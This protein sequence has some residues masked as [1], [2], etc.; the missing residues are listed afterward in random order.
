MLEKNLSQRRPD[1]VGINAGR[2]ERQK[3]LHRG[4]GEKAKKNLRKTKVFTALICGAFTLEFAT[5]CV[6][7]AS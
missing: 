4:Y 6:C 5:A 3:I 2:R 7:I 1:Y